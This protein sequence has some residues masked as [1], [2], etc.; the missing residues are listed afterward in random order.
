[1]FLSARLRRLTLCRLIG[2]QWRRDHRQ[3]DR[4]LAPP[5]NV[6]FEGHHG[7]FGWPK[8]VDSPIGW[9]AS[10]ACRATSGL[11]ALSQPSTAVQFSLERARRTALS[12]TR[13][14]CDS[15]VPMPG[16]GPVGERISRGNSTRLMRAKPTGPSLRLA[17]AA[18]AGCCHSVA[19]EVHELRRTPVQQRSVQRT[20]TRAEPVEAETVGRCSPVAPRRNSERCR[21]STDLGA[22]PPSET[23]GEI[24]P[25]PPGVSQQPF[26]GASFSRTSRV[27]PPTRI[28]E[29][30]RP[31]GRPRRRSLFLLNASRAGPP[32]A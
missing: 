2:S 5:E 20:T 25:S 3:P 22:G 15:P 30:V 12:A 13:R 16:R 32:L 21:L 24:N 4:G 9:R 29:A 6:A 26:P 8:A 17:M 1:M 19:R 11:E 28:A 10:S 14:G 7:L 18:L 27:L 23:A 31:W